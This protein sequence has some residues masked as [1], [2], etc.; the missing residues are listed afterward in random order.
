MSRAKQSYLYPSQLFLDA[1][2]LL[3]PLNLAMIIEGAFAAYYPGPHR[4]TRRISRGDE[5]QAAQK[6]K[7]DT[8]QF[9][10]SSWYDKFLLL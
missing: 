2:G 6:C 4:G 9:T 3:T 10:G 8:C 5:G 7:F 1:G